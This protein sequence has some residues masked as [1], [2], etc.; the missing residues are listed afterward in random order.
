MTE[1]QRY[2]EPDWF[3]R[4]VI[5]RAVR[6]LTRLGVSV[7][8][9]RELRVRGRKSGQWRTTPVNLLTLGGQRYLVAPRGATQWV[10]NLRASGVGE[11]R[12]GRRIEGFH[13]DELGDDAKAPILREYLR[14]WNFEAGMFFVG[15]DADASDEQLRH[16]APGFPVFVIAAA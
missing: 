5:N 4:S 16:V 1:E 9:S 15:L 10:R 11:L 13:A 2:L 12:I 8:G 14:R 6:G 3:T 7:W